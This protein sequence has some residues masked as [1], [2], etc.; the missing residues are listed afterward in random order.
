MKFQVLVEDKK[1]K[2]ILW[3]LLGAIIL[4]L[5][6]ILFYRSFAFY[7]EK[8][9]FDLISGEVTDQFYDMMISFIQIDASGKEQYV[10]EIPEGKNWD[11]S[12]SCD[13]GAEGFWDINSWRLVTSNITNTRTKCKLTFRPYESPL[14]SFGISDHVVENGDGLYKVDHSDAVIN[15][16]LSE[17]QRS[18]LK[19]MEYRYA[20]ANPNNYVRF[21]NELWRIIGLV[22]TPDGSRLKIVRNSSIGLYSWDSSENNVNGGLGV[23]E[24]TRSDLMQLLNEGA[25]Y[26][27]SEGTCY[28]G[29]GNASVPCDFSENGLMESAKEMIYKTL[30]LLG[31]NGDVEAFDQSNGLVNHYYN[32]ERSNRHGKNCS[33]EKNL[34]TDTVERGTQWRGNVG[35]IYAS[36]YAYAMSGLSMKN[37]NYC[38]NQILQQLKEENVPE[39]THSNWLLRGGNQWLITPYS[40][41]EG[42]NYALY[43]NPS[44][45]VNI[46]GSATRNWI[47]PSVY[48]KEEVYIQS[49]EGSRESPYVLEM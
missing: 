3:L 12:V 31:T 14:S 40:Y 5:A 22:N 41:L 29:Q 1:K 42:S 34:C 48:L 36:D 30:W 10:S 32:Y 18:N 15:A 47:Y 49:G 8:K 26:N 45:Y 35:L 37:Q 17:T 23:N 19:N 27:R 6:I 4:I 21:N 24:W 38:L 11:V 25:Y 43:I 9:S 28:N 39:C 7:E 13:K 46:D 2:K 16:P 44:G 20:G 33:D